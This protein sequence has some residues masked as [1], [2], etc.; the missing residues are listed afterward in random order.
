MPSFRLSRP[1]PE[2]TASRAAMI[3]DEMRA[4]VNLRQYLPSAYAKRKS[5]VN[6]DGKFESNCI[7]KS[8]FRNDQ[9]FGTV[10]F[11]PLMGYEI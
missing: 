2:R 3:R 6:D 10:S 9:I 8:A 5:G 7:C 4:Y 11:G 1:G